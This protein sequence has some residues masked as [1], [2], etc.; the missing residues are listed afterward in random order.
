MAGAANFSA[1][2]Y[3]GSSAGL[4][5]AKAACWNDPMCGGVCQALEPGA[6][7]TCETSVLRH[8]R[9]TGCDSAS[10]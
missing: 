2:S 10:G 7:N 8:E 1:C 6:C 9:R 4:E 3:E 5:A